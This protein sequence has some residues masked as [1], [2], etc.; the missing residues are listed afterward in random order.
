MPHNGI[1]TGVDN[2]VPSV[3]LDAD[4]LLEEL[5]DRLCPCQTYHPGDQ[6]GIA[7]HATPP[8]YV[9]PVEA[10]I[11]QGCQNGDRQHGRSEDRQQDPIPAFRPLMAV[12]PS[13][14]DLG[15]DPSQV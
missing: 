12:D 9:K 11:V 7:H 1:R 10:T 5:V 8:R 3:H 13:G 2:P 4:G 6:K 15:I 14:D